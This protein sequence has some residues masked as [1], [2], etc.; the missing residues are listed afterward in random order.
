MKLNKHKNKNKTSN[1]MK[2]PTYSIVTRNN[3]YSNHSLL[4]AKVIFHYV[5]ANYV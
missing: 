3:E 5:V 2:L 4:S 1:D